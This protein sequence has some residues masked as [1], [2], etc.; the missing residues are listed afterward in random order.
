MQQIS[1][2]DI[3]PQILRSKAADRGRRVMREFWALERQRR[4]QT[5]GPEPWFKADDEEL[6]K[7]VSGMTDGRCAFCESASD[8][9]Q[10]HRFRPPGNA[11]PLQGSGNGHLY[12]LWLADAWQNLYP[13]CPTC[14]PPEPQFPLQG[15]RASLPSLRQVDNYVERGDGLWPSFPPKEA[16]ELLDPARDDKFERHFV[17]KLDGELIGESK[18]GETTALIFNLNRPDLRSRRYHAYHNLLQRLMTLMK[19]GQLDAADP[20]WAS[21]FAFDDMEFGGTWYLLLRRLGRWA[22]NSNGARWRMSRRLMRGFFERCVRDLKADWI[23]E[24]VETLA[25][26]DQG[27]RAGRWG[28]E[29]V[30]SVRDS[31]ASI[32]IS[33]F[34]AIEQIGLVLGTPDPTTD[35]PS[36]RRAPSLVILGENATGKSSILEAIGLCVSTPAA[37]NALNPR[38]ADFTLDP[39]QFGAERERV[40]RHSEVR[41]VLASGQAANLSIENGSAMVRNEFGNQQVAVFAYGAFRRFMTSTRRSSPH[42]HIRNLFDGATLSNPEPWLKS[43]PID[44][45]NMVI[46]TLRDLLSVEG[47]FDI[48]Q[49][50]GRSK[51]LRMVTSLVE[52]DGT[53]RFNRTPLQVVSSGYRAM[54]G[55]L[56]DIMRGLL[57]PQVYENFESFQTARGVV[58]I[59]EIEAHLHP[60]W[61][62]QV[63]TSLRAALPGMTFIV[64]T[65]DPLCLRGMGEGEVVVLQRV[66]TSD[67]GRESTLPIIVERIE[68]LPSVAGLRVEQ[69]LTS[70]FFQLLSSDDAASDRR[71]AQIGDLIAA[72]SN[73]EALSDTDRYV[74]RAFEEDIANALPVGSSEVHRIAQEAVAEYLRQR[75]DASSVRLRRLR[76]EAKSEILKALDMV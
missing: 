29:S 40:A 71:L 60:R 7:A 25:R 4:A 59:D 11:L 70:D 30:Y 65:H 61:K 6:V 62:V 64:T 53:I 34:K 54:L 32:S 16:N 35:D 17:P 10:V 74:L 68:N 26:E 75:R 14:V 37:R 13:I 39:T 57:D 9:L 56:C 31:I 12:Y 44:Q 55:M 69:L 15:G 8:E 46:R 49:R 45:F 23:D 2:S 27:L 1:R 18:R 3:V 73:G 52:P 48:I 21:L 36:A 33:N 51:Q 41:I 42:K 24:A 19:S 58:L 47:D 28:V 22:A 38:W 67:S 63:M 43:L 76:T 72:K 50:Y 5:S 66:A 20:D